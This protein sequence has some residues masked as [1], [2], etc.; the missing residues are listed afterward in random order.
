M[1]Y[2]PLASLTLHQLQVF[3]VTARSGSMRDAAESLGISVPTLS[4]QIRTLERTIGVHLLI[5]SPGRRGI[6]L[7][8]NGQILAESSQNALSSLQDGLQR[9]TRSPEAQRA[10]VEFGCGSTFSEQLL[11][12]LYS[13]FRQQ[14][15]DID[16]RV[17][18]VSKP[19][20]LERLR[21]G[22]LDL[23]VCFGPVDDPRL[24]AEPLG[25]GF[26]LSLFTRPEHPL[27]GQ[28]DIPVRALGAEH[29][30]LAPM[31]SVI[32]GLLQRRFNDAGVELQVAWEITS[33]RARL[34]AAK[35]GLGITA[36][37]NNMLGS[38]AT[39]DLVELDVEGFPIPC[40]W[41]LTWRPSRLSLAAATFRE[42][43]L[44]HTAL[45]V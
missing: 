17:S 2:S 40:E 13:G 38:E 41:M 24:S 14:H 39:R 45:P 7:T 25:L 44:T 34:Q 28:R 8:A 6:Q 26:D 29:F 35:S 27:A 36:V 11:P 37:G 4:E 42:Y 22:R 31:P 16:L 5:R 1:P 10:V 21:R 33:P 9:M 12:D 30:V 19:H 23:G 15:P 20:L 32:R 43:L 3:L 18:V